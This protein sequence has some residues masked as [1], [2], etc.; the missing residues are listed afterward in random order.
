MVYKTAN[1]KQT[2][3]LAK[4]IVGKLKPG[5][6]LALYGDLGSGKTTFVQGL[7]AALGVKATVNSPTFT[8]VKQYELLIHADLYRL[9]SAIDAETTGLFDYLGSPHHILVIEWPKVIERW[10][11]AKTKKIYFKTTNETTREIIIN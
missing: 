6:I 1:E 8:F 5:D 3:A 10:L 2:K 11:P 4:Q 7:A 9:K